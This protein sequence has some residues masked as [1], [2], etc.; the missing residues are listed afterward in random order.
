[1]TLWPSCWSQRDVA[2]PAITEYLQRR[3]ATAQAFAAQGPEQARLVGST[4]F[5]LQNSLKVYLGRTR[6]SRRSAILAKKQA[7]E[8]DFRAKVAANPEWKKAYGNSLGRRS[9]APKKRSS[10]RSRASSSA[11]P[12]AASSRIA[13]QIVQYVAEI[14]KARRRAPAAIP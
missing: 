13:L 11:A 9:P 3:I 8:T 10:R 14:T 7:E 2:G 12:T 6:S 4:I 5:G 1:M